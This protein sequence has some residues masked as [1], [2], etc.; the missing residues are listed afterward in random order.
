MRVID[1]VIKSRLLQMQQTLFNNAQASMEIQAL[2]P[3][4][5]IFHPRFWQETIVSSGVTATCTSISVRKTGSIADRVFVA[6]V[7]NGV[8]TVKSAAL[9]YPISNMAWTQELSIPNCSGCALEFDGSFVRVPHG[10]VEF[11]TESIPWLFYTTTGNQLMGGLLGGTY[12]AIAGNVTAFDSIRGVAS[13]YK[14]IDQ[15]FI[16]FYIVSGSV[17]YR[18]RISGVWEEQQTVGLTP[19]GAVSIK[20]ERTFDW[21][22]VLQI[23]DN[24]GALHEVFT[25]MAISA[26]VNYEQLTAK[27]ENTVAVYEVA[28]LDTMSQHE[29]LTG[30][31]DMVIT[32]LWGIAPKVLSI[33][34]EDDGTG[35]HGF[36]VRITFDADLFSVSGNAAAFSMVDDFAASYDCTAIGQDG[37][38]LILTFEDFNNATNPIMLTYTPGTIIGEVELVEAFALE[39]SATELDPVFQEPPAPVSAENIIDWEAT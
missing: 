24:T 4:T 35:D 16:V 19:A 28:Y 8:L 22:I 39:F 7:S 31:I 6:Y 23:T 33:A 26:H 25:K 11:R 13:I 37:R 1:P 34:N 12:E 27:I 2:R 15:G 14:D 36:K 18:Q 3:R 20:A 30:L 17:Y 5:A 9:T 38:E 29:Y 21:R 32:T 10:K